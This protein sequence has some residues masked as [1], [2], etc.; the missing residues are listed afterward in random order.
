MDKRTSELMKCQILGGSNQAMW[1][2]QPFGI[3]D[4]PRETFSLLGSHY[5]GFPVIKVSDEAKRRIQ[6]GEAVNFTYQNRLYRVQGD[7]I[8]EITFGC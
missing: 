4:S 3:A 6:R 1:A 2:W 7:E 8:A 5:R